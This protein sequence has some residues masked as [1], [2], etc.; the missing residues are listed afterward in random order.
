VTFA[1]D[2]GIG[3]AVLT[4]AFAAIAAGTTAKSQINFG[5]ST[6]PTSPNN[7]DFWF[8]GTNLNIRIS[9]STKTLTHS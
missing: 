8:D 5:A 4:S 9:G 6:A 7:G 1:D 3:T 2:V